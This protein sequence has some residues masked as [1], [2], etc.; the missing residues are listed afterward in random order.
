MFVISAALGQ[1]YYP[2]PYRWSRILLFFVLM[3]IFYGVA[4]GLG[5]WLWPSA[6]I[7]WAQL[8]VNT[9]LILLYCGVCYKL[10][11]GQYRKIGTL[12]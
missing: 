5:A 2:I 6:G 9:V 1:K 8:G 10:L 11:I 3:G 7:H 12:A 4:Y